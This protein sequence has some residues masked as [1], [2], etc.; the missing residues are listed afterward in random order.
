M[1]SDDAFPPDV[2]ADAE[3]F[4]DEVDEDTDIP[5]TLGTHEGSE[6]DVVD[7]HRTV[8]IDDDDE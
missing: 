6:A 8:P 7:Q 1:D 2:D 5:I 4:V 3:R